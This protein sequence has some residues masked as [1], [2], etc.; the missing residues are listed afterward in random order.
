MF[1]NAEGPYLY[2]PDEFTPEEWETKSFA[3]DR[4]LFKYIL[5][6]TSVSSKLTTVIIKL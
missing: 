2:D 3:L 6:A 4:F 5:P 1:G